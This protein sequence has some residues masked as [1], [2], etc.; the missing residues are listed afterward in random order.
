M[1]VMLDWAFKVNRGKPA[2][3]PNLSAAWMRDELKKLDKKEC[4]TKHTQFYA[5]AR[6]DREK[7][8]IALS[9]ILDKN[10]DFKAN[11]NLFETNYFNDSKKTS[12]TKCYFTMSQVADAEGLPKEWSDE[13][14]ARLARALCVRRGYEIRP[15]EDPD[16]AA[17]GIEQALYEEGKGKVTTEKVRGKTTGGTKSM[18]VTDV[19]NINRQMKLMNDEMDSQF[20]DE[21][22]GPEQL[23]IEDDKTGSKRRNQSAK[24]TREA[25]KE[26]KKEES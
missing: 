14:R 4:T 8:K 23:A 22:E 25:R 20:D 11:L 6:G 26:Q 13:K 2:P 5:S 15:H 10:C 7:Q 12:V 9:L 24:A 16:L 21:R 19:D 3:K 17:E 1:R 18:N